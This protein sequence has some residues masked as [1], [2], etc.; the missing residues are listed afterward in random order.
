MNAVVGVVMFIMFWIVVVVVV[1][2]TVVAVVLLIVV[3]SDV[4]MLP[5]V[6]VVRDLFVPQNHV[7]R[8]LIECQKRVK[9]G[10]ID[11]SVLCDAS[12]AIDCS[13]CISFGTKV[14]KRPW[15]ERQSYE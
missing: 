6:M 9:I 8:P 4:I 11:Y 2:L 5:V 13:S 12:L 15:Y 7:L 3:V 1:W 14:L 10:T